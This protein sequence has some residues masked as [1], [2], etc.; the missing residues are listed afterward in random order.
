MRASDRKR[1]EEGQIKGRHQQTD[2]QS[3]DERVG[4]NERRRE[5]KGGKQEKKTQ[6]KS[7]WGRVLYGRYPPPERQRMGEAEYPLFQ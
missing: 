1:W 7:L 4:L 3:E 5:K 2:R 6:R